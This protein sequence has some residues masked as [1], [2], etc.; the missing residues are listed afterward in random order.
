MIWTPAIL[1]FVAVACGVLTMAL[2]WEGWRDRRRKREIAE[3]IE[4]G[5][6]TQTYSELFR[7]PVRT[8]PEWLD[9]LA[10]RLPHI[11][12]LQHLLD[13][14][15]V[16]WHVGTFVI[17][18]VGTSVACG[19]FGL[20]LTSNVI[21]ALVLSMMG[22]TVPYL[23]VRWKKRKRMEAFLENF[24]D[25]IDLLG[26]AIRAGHA[27]ST[28]LQM[29]GEEAGEPVAGEFRR[30]F[31]EQKFG[32]PIDESLFELSD[33]IDVVDVQ[34]FV[35]AV[36]IQREVGG[37]LAEILDTLAGTIRERFKIERQ[38]RVYTAQGRLTG[39]LLACLPLVVGFLIYLLNK[40]YMTILFVEPI[41]RMLIAVAVIMQ[42]I[43]Y[44]IIRRIVDIKV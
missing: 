15:A 26:R 32:L 10:D 16:S 33:R 7:D 5:A 24:P 1:V 4:T 12:D 18:T 38:V 9:P 40:E 22:G 36:L 31:E 30:V 2:L 8:G 21:I 25:A 44:F 19:I 6:A 37:N 13:Q 3:R 14:A 42:I 20:L 29:I 27:F 23:Y 17:F 11:R 39:Y 35:T 28:G 34:I 43:G 41:G